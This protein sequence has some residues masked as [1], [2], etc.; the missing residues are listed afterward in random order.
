MIAFCYIDGKIAFGSDVPDGALPFCRG[1]ADVLIPFVKVIAR[2][3]RTSDA[4]L[5]PGVPECNAVY[6]GGEKALEALQRFTK[7]I[8]PMAKKKGLSVP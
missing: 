5:V 7:L 3:D 1:D 4:L 6:E 2:H 8:E